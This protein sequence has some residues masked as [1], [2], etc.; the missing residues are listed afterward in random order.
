MLKISNFHPNTQHYEV[1]LADI[2]ESAAVCRVQAFSDEEN[3]TV[4][5]NPSGD[6]AVVF[7]QSRIFSIIVANASGHRTYTVHVTYPTTYVPS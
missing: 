3:A 7:D 6:Q 5:V 4:T 1:D 2:D